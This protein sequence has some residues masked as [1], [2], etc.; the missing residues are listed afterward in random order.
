MT[1]ATIIIMKSIFVQ[2]G[3]DS[4]RHNWFKWRDGPVPEGDKT[5]QAINVFDFLLLSVRS[6]CPTA[7][8]TWKEPRPC[9]EKNTRVLGEYFFDIIG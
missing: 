3:A 7:Q 8:F 4:G 5:T 1:I 6:S 9:S 2:G